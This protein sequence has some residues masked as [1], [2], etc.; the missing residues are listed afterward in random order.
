MDR[1]GLF[2]NSKHKYFYQVQQQMHVTKRNWTDF[3]VKASKSSDIFCQRIEFSKHFWEENFSKLHN[4]Y[5]RWIA[6]EIAY[7]RIKHG[8]P[9]F[10]YRSV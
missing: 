4:F 6:P 5:D 9:K 1:N 10:D 2:L 8:L 7:Q 3:V